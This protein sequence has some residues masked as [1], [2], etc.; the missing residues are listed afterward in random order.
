ML[1][2]LIFP[3]VAFAESF[4]EAITYANRD[5]SARYQYRGD[6]FVSRNVNRLSLNQNTWKNPINLGGVS[7]HA[8]VYGNPWGDYRNG[9]YR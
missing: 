3:A 7:A 5:I 6:F 4:Q 8:L 2:L 9:Q 1:M